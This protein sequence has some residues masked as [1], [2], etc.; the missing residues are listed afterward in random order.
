MV[1]GV[2]SAT[3]NFTSASNTDQMQIDFEIQ[4]KKNFN[5]QQSIITFE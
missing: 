1:S 2:E 4:I 5:I 3:P